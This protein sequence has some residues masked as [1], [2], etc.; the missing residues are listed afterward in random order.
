[1]AVS[2]APALTFSSLRQT[3]VKKNFAPVYLLHGEESYFID[4]L[5]RLFDEAVPE[6]ERDFNLY[7]LYAPQTEPATIVETCRRFPMMA[8]RQIVI[9]KE[10]QSVSAD[11]LNKIAPYLNNPVATTVLVVCSR[12]A[13][14]KSK[15]LTGAV[16]KVGGVIFESKKLTE[17][18]IEP[19]I[20]AIVK[21]KGLN[22]EAKS[23]AMLKEYIGLDASRLFNEISKL[24]MIL[25]RGSMITP[26]SIERNIGV[27]KDFNNFELVDAVAAR[28]QLKIF[29]IAAYFERNPKNN[30]TV[31]TASALFSFFSDLLIAHFTRD[32]SSSSLQA[33]LGYKWSGQ[34]T[35]INIGLKN[36]NAYQVI[37]IISAIRRFDANVKGIG[38]RQ[39]EYGLLHDLL[40]HILNA[41]GEIII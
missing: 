35:K 31:L 15:E 39:P 38:S 26:E 28:N 17:R 32:K 22:I 8:D 3:I 5:A 25:G 30:P 18:N 14:C 24:A 12:G 40:F 21:E 37:E 6:D 20:A 13:L 2:S 7:T 36:Y 34:L 33:A 19:A 1:M 11:Y 41:R 10:A 23:M 16:R 27:S 4:E 9:V 29:R